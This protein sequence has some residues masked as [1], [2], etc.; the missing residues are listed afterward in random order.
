MFLVAK[1]MWD[2]VTHNETYVKKDAKVM[3][4]ICLMVDETLFLII[5]SNKL[6]NR[7]KETTRKTKT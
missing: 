2:L 6:Y 7:R 4:K 1:D 3:S 5:R